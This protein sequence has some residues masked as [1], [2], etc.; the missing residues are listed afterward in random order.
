[1]KQTCLAILATIIRFRDKY[2]RSNLHE[3]VQ[4]IFALLSI[5]TIYTNK[6]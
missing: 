2:H 4:E 6:L 3:E 5:C 1:M